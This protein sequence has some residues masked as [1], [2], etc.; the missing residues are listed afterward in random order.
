MLM[1]CYGEKQVIMLQD[2]LRTRQLKNGLSKHMH[3]WHQASAD[4]SLC[5]SM[6]CYNE[7]AKQI[8]KK[9]VDGFVCANM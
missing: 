3:S 9:T 5:F 6:N 4:S 8:T 2:G 1:N 7:K